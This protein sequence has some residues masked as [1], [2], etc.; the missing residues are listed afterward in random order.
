MVNATVQSGTSCHLLIVIAHVS[1]SKHFLLFRSKFCNFWAKKFRLILFS[2]CDFQFHFDSRLHFYVKF[3]HKTVLF[4]LLLLVSLL[5]LMEFYV[6]REED[7]FIGFA[8]TLRNRL[9]QHVVTRHV[10]SGND[11]LPKVHW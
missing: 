9:I 5:V 10:E 8:K 3:I 6:P 4:S 1:L 2:M 7:P 11:L